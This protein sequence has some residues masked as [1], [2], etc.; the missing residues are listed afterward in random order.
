MISTERL[1]LRENR[2]S[3]GLKPLN[4]CT[5]EETE[6]H[7]VADFVADVITDGML[8]SVQTQ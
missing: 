4:C 5:R 7:P 1:L 8:S 3:L 2:A 6:R